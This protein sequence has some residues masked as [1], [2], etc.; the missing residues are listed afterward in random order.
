MASS[1]HTRPAWTAGIRCTQR[2]LSAHM[3]VAAAVDPPTWLPT[4]RRDC[5]PADAHDAALESRAPFHVQTRRS[6]TADIPV[7]TGTG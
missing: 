5:R 6:W 1:L 7:G 2:H 3:T 4:R